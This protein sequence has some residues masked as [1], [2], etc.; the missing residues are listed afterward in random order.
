MYSSVYTNV[1]QQSKDEREG[2]VLGTPLP[3]YQEKK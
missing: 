3:K 1:L 2:G